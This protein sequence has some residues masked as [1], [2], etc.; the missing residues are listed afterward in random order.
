MEQNPDGR[1]GGEGFASFLRFELTNLP[2]IRCTLDQSRDGK[3][4][5]KVGQGEMI[6]GRMK[7]PSVSAFVNPF[8][9][10]SS[11]PLL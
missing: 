3:R 6:V 4:C 11:S 8:L 9:A 10:P 1:K 5:N 7:F 2:G